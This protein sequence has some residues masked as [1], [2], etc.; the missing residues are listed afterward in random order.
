H[1]VLRFWCDRGVDGFRIDVAHKL[2]KDPLLRDRAPGTRVPYEDWEPQIHERLRRLR[3]VVDEYPDRM[4]VGEV[5]LLDLERVVTYINTGVELHLAHNFVFLQL[6]WDAGAFRRSIDGFEGL[7]T[8]HA[9]PAWFLA[10]HDHARVASRFDH[11]GLGAARAR[12][13]LL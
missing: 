12:A 9:W 4:L 3:D 11:D 13:V 2:A 1:D 10:N 5:Y 8:E 7:S 6:P